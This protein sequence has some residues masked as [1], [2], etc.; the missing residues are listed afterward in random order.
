MAGKARAQI[1][2]DYLA[3][4]ALSGLVAAGVEHAIATGAPAKRAPSVAGAARSAPR[5]SDA[6]A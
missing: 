2:K 6:L 1:V 5:C 4:P 3:W